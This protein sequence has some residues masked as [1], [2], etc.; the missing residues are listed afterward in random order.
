MINFKNFFESEGI[1]VAG[2]I[3]TTIDSLDDP[4]HDLRIFHTFCYSKD[5]LKKRL[6]EI[7]EYTASLF[8]EI[9][10]DVFLFH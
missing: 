3:T 7:V 4:V 8:D 10:L 1:I 2:G 9:I 6:Q 5:S